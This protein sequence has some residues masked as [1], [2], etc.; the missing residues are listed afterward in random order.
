[1]STPIGVFICVQGLFE[2][3][4]SI[5]FDAVYH[6]RVLKEQF[7]GDVA[8][9]LFCERADAALYPDVAIEP[10]N[11]FAAALAASPEA[12][13]LYHYCDGWAELEQQLIEHSRN[14]IVR[15]HNNTPPWFFAKY[16]LRFVERTVR[17]FSAI[18]RL[19]EA[20]KCRFWC[21]SEFTLR[22]LEFL[23][24]DR[25]RSDVVYPASRY[26]DAE[27][28]ISPPAAAVGSG[29]SILFVG[30]IVPHKGHKQ[31][32]L[33][34]AYLKQRLGIPAELVLPGRIDS[35]MPEYGDDLQALARRLDVPLVLPGEVDAAELDA[36]YRQASVFLC[37][38]EHEGFGLPI[39]EAMRMAKPTL[40]WANTATAELLRGHP[41]AHPELSPRWFAAAIAALQEPDIRRYVLRWQREVA[42][43]RYTGAVVRRQIGHGLAPFGLSE[44]GLQPDPPIAAAEGA[45]PRL[46][47]YLEQRIADYSAA[48]G[49]DPLDGETG[50]AREIPSNF[51]SGYDIEAYEALISLGLTPALV[52][53]T[54]DGS[55]AAGGI[56]VPASRFS[57]TS[58]RLVDGNYVCPLPAPVGHAIFGPHC[59]LPAG[60]YRVEFQ[61]QVCDVAEREETG[62]FVFDVAIG[63][64]EA[65]CERVVSLRE[66]R[67]NGCIS[68]DFLQPRPEALTEFRIFARSFESG[69][70]RFSGAVLA[71]LGAAVAW[72]SRWT[73]GRLLPLLRE[74]RR[75][76]GRR[77]K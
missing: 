43:H 76:T 31:D 54:P 44:G 5:G 37:L 52:Q 20:T 1:M 17:G 58:G 23:G 3:S 18:I 65:L 51:V 36:C 13:V 64:G 59:L 56:L 73:L 53:R 77:P 11:E 6:Y 38:S 47:A 21:N 4:D 50:I 24:V 12:L 41:L 49:D 60:A 29:A 67:R 62:E 46:A 39:F 22:Q 10:I 14:L 9:R 72:Q 71:P 25:R 68:L 74:R 42:L 33:T 2:K 61:I 8:V 55:A 57:S 48:I 35:G 16:A 70:L 27:P 7:L 69:T 26:L 66:F 19:A 40:A 45:D 75:K 28:E 15:W 30:R 32:L 63:A 34:A